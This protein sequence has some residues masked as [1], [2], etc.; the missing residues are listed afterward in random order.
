VALGVH[1]FELYNEP[2]VAGPA[3]GW[4]EGQAVNV[5]RMVD[6]WLAAAQ[7]VHAAGGYPSLPPLA[8]G[9]TVDD[10]TFLREFLAGVRARGQ[11]GLLPGSWLAVHNY[12]LNHP[13]DYPTDPVNVND[14]PLTEAEIAE[15]GLTPEQV[16]AINHARSIAKLPR[17]QGG[18]WVGNTVDEDSNAFYKFDAYANIF[19]RRFGYYLPVIGTEGGAIVGAAEDP[20]YPPVREA[21]LTRLTLGAYHTLLDNAP[22]YFFAQTAWLMANHAA[23]HE[24]ER[25][26]QATWYKDRQGTMLPVVAALKADPRKDE[27]RAWHEPAL[28]DS[29]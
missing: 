11:A 24:D 26:E 23:E 12:F 28:E 15:R 2:N 7:E 16:E 22:P 5:E 19:Y 14:I 8:G 10:M 21:D 18:F 1:Y 6:L 4:P 13:L 25:F 3:G 9:G 27:V 20:R 29:K 17:E